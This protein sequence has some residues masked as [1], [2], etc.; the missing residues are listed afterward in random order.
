LDAIVAELYGLTYDDFAWILRDCA[1]QTTEIR[2]RYHSFDPKGFW[3]VDKAQDPELRHTVLALKAFSDLKSL[4]LKMFCALNGGDGWTIPEKLVFEINADGTIL[5]D[6]LE[7]K[8]MPVRERLGPRF[9]DWQLTGTPE[10]SWSECEEHARNMLGDK[11]LDELMASS[12]KDT[13]SGEGGGIDPKDKVVVD[14]QTVL[15][16]AEKQKKELDA[17]EKAQK[18]LDDW[19]SAS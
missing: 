18:T 1:Y 14:V 13:P 8:T 17:E 11:M 12:L 7:G 2:D 3:R 16:K 6:T 5:F 19:H 9:L 4:G 15:Q 10:E